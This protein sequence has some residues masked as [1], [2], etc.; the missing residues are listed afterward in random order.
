ML[1]HANSMIVGWGLLEGAAFMG[2][3]AY[4]LEARTLALGVIAI[5]LLLMF[6]TFPTE[7]RAR[8]WLQRQTALVSSLAPG[9]G[10]DF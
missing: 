9:R 2:C 5:V 7:A 10:R 1:V 6:C 8:N 3:M 4:L